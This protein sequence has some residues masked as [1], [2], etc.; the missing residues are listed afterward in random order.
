MKEM[1]VYA[2][3]TCPM[4]AACR[5]LEGKWKIPMIYVLNENGTL[6]YNELKRALGITNMMLSNTLK[7]LEEEGLVIRVQYNEIPPR[8]EY[9][10]SQLS[11]QLIPVLDAFCQWGEVLL[12]Q[13]QRECR[14]SDDYRDP[15]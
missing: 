9:H 10:L 11:R 14:G 4:R 13:E 6:R 1:I 8:V 12:A 15:E 2:S 3:E 5:A 7:E